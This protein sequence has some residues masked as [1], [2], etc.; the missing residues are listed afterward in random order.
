MEVVSSVR[1][2][3]ITGGKT[4]GDVTQD[5]CVRVEAKPPKTWMLALA[6]SLSLVSHW[7]LYTV[8]TLLGRYRSLGIE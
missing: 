6:V 2:P 8:Q 7:N 4:V 5:I 1:D 3:L